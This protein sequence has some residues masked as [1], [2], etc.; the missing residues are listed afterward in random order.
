M[1]EVPNMDEFSSFPGLNAMTYIG[2]SEIA[3]ISHNYELNAENLPCNL[4]GNFVPGLIYATGLSTETIMYPCVPID[5]FMLSCLNGISE[6]QMS[7]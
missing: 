7:W 4:L 1:H 5:D 6:S 3:T 2:R